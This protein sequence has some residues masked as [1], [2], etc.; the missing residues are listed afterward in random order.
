[1]N[2]KIDT[3]K[4]VVIVILV[5]IIVCGGMFLVSNNS[6]KNENTKVSDSDSNIEEKAIE[7]SNSVLDSEK[8]DFNEIT[9][10]QYLEFYNGDSDSIVLVARPT[11]Y[12]CQIAEPIIQ[13]VAYKYDLTINYL[14]TDNFSDEDQASLVRSNDYFESFGTPVV[15]IV[16]NGEIKNKLEGLTISDYYINFFKETGFILEK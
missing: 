2:N 7:E 6:S 14:N 9:L 16:S 12:Y 13:N 15:L 5:L 4:N 11:C 8:K 1:M 3:I 10:S